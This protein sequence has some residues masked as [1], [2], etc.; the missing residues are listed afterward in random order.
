MVLSRY[1]MV[2]FLIL[3]L[4]TFNSTAQAGEYQWEVE[5]EQQGG[6]I[7]RVT[8]RGINLDLNTEDWN[9]SNDNGASILERNY[10]NWS[11]YDKAGNSLPVTVQSKNYLLFSLLRLTYDSD[12]G[13]ETD[14]F[15][16]LSSSADGSIK[17][18]SLGIIQESSATQVDNFDKEPW[19]TWDIK[20]NQANT[21]FNESAF[22]LKVAFVDGLMISL[23]I[24]FFGFTAIAIWYLIYIKR[25]N[26]IIA[27]EYSLENIDKILLEKEEEAISEETK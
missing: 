14:L 8:L 10:K 6:I 27:E 13:S 26:K 2:T 23:I 24:L 15:S 25:V 20:S 16:Q 21:A 22:Y 3:F 1:F 4:F 17:Y 12:K 7:E 19:A 5:V 9:Q 11:E 18:K